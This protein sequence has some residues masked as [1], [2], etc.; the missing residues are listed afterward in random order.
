M[1]MPEHLEKLIKTAITKGLGISFG[2]NWNAQNRAD[3]NDE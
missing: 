2:R 1:K 3:R